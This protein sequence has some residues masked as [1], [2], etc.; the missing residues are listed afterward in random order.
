MYREQPLEPLAI[1]RRDGDVGV[2][3]EALHPRTP[4]R[5]E[6]LGSVHGH[7]IAHALDGSADTRAHGHAPHDRSSIQRRESRILHGERVRLGMEV[8]PELARALEGTPHAAADLLGARDDFLVGGWVH[9][10]EAYGAVL[11]DGVDAVEDDQ[12]EVDVERQRARESLDHGAP[13][14]PAVDDAV[15][16]PRPPTQIGEDGASEGPQRDRARL[17]VVCEAI[18]DRMRQRE[19]PLKYRRNGGPVGGRGREQSGR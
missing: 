2:Q 15:P 1:A 5:R 14:G 4:P 16:S 6:L 7:S 11:T 10:R 12:V 3:R 9:R 8:I 13:T 18:A 19:D 17:V